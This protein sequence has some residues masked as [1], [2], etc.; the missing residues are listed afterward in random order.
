MRH[1]NDP[2]GLTEDNNATVLNVSI[3]VPSLVNTST[4]GVQDQIPAP[5]EPAQPWNMT[6]VRN[7]SIDLGAGSPLTIELMYN[8]LSI[9]NKMFFAYT[10]AAT[11]YAAQYNP[12]QALMALRGDFDLAVKSEIDSQRKKLLR[13]R[14][15]CKLLR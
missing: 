3:A 12:N 14:H 6:T 5:V 13:V 10:L 8:G 1:G 9:Q 11:S 2:W 15:V 4:E 7:D